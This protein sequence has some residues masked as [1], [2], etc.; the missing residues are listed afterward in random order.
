MGAEHPFKRV[1]SNPELVDEVASKELASEPAGQPQAMTGNAKEAAEAMI[2]SSVRST[3]LTFNIESSTSEGEGADKAKSAGGKTAGKERKGFSVMGLIHSCCFVSDSKVDSFASS[4][5]YGQRG[6]TG[7]GSQLSRV[8]SR[9]P[10]TPGAR[11]KGPG[12]DRKYNGN[13]TYMLPPQSGDTLGKKTLVLDLDETL[14]HSSFDYLPDA[15]LVL[16]VEVQG[17][18]QEVYVRKRPG[19]DEF[20]EFVG[21]HY[22]VGVFTASVIKYADAVLDRIDKTQ[23]VQWR[24]FRE[25]CCQTS[26]GFYVKDLGC[27][28]RRLES[29]IIIDN[30]PHSYLFHPEN[31]IGIKSFVDDKRDNHLIDLIPF[32]D[33]TKEAKDVREALKLLD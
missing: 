26:E 6:G 10:G 24:L 22:E 25:S 15:D 1:E 31:A 14:V 21:K 7:P 20:L 27:L 11:D 29:T 19:L 9:L 33:H 18:T 28:G 32:L 8:F 12:F 17:I 2:T 5:A 13:R 30:S 16:P 23:V 4:S 3:N